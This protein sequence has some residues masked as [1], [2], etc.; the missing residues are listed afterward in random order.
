MRDDLNVTALTI[1]PS[2]KEI[3]GHHKLFIG[4]FTDP[5]VYALIAVKEMAVIQHCLF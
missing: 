2:D 4:N 1:V 3:I 5:Q